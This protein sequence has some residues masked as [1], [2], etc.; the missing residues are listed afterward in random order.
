MVRTEHEERG[1]KTVVEISQAVIDG[2]PLSPDT[3]SQ[4]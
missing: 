4:N 3:A 1:S 2:M